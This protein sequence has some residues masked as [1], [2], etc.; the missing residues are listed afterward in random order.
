MPRLFIDRI[1]SIGAVVDG[2]NEQAEILFAKAAPKV[3]DNLQDMTP[4]ALW[5][6]LEELTAGYRQRRNASLAQAVYALYRVQHSAVKAVVDA[7]LAAAVR[8]ATGKKEP[9]MK[10]RT[11]TTK[12]E[13]ITDAINTAVNNRAILMQHEQAAMFGKN[14]AVVRAQ[15][16][17]SEVGRQLV[18]LMRRH[19]AKPY[20]SVS[21]H[22]PD[23]AADFIRKWRTL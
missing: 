18:A 7:Y 10:A 19:G 1:E 6:L 2:D 8:A 3:P 14:I 16:W 4:G 5:T 23:A 22:A 21:K 13:T 11:M 20:S 15:V 12:T 17:Q 9:T